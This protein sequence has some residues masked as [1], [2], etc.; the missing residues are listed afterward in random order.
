[1]EI[2]DFCSFG[3]FPSG[4]LHQ[5]PFFILFHEK[6][7]EMK[8]KEFRSLCSLHLVLKSE[9]LSKIAH[10]RI[11]FVP[12]FATWFTL[13]TTQSHPDYFVFAFFV[14]S[15]SEPRS[16]LLG[17]KRSSRVGCAWRVRFCVGTRNC[18]PREGIL[19]DEMVAEPLSH[20]PRLLP[21]TRRQFLLWH[22]RLSL[23]LSPLPPSLH[24]N[25]HLH[26][27]LQAATRACGRVCLDTTHVC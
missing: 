13:C 24:L 26:N 20:L 3:I 14:S 4:S 11:S 21:K 16:P 23:Y 17:H 10:L 27:T 1:M 7:N 25:L 18:R 22:A 5:L 8:M 9:R 19:T 15:F 2:H 6:R 12:R